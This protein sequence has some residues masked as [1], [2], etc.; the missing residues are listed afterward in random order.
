MFSVKRAAFLAL[1][2]GTVAVIGSPVLA[3][4]PGAPGAPGAPGGPG[5]K[6][7]SRMERMVKELNLTDKQ[8]KELKPIMDEQGKA[9]KALRD[10]KVTPDADKRAKMKAI[11]DANKPKIEKILTKEQI[12][13]FKEMS[14]RR[15]GPGGPGGPG[16]KHDDKGAKPGPGK[17]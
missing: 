10:D 17:P 14:T 7:M 9:M 3:Q 4:K 12:V 8:Q 6:R 16:G 13:K 2:L 11:M 1:A 15:R 5:G